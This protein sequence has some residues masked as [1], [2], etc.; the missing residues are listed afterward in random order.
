[1]VAPWMRRM[2]SAFRAATRMLARRFRALGTLLFSSASSSPDPH[3][4]KVEPTRFAQCISMATLPP[5]G[6]DTMIFTANKPTHTVRLP[7]QPLAVRNDCVCLETAPAHFDACACDIRTFSLA[8]AM[9]SEREDRRAGLSS[10]A[11]GGWLGLVS[12]DSAGAGG[13]L[14]S[15]TSCLEQAQSSGLLFFGA[16]LSFSA[17]DHIMIHAGA[18]F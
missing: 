17:G 13:G 12:H 2:G 18:A 1:M 10:I 14:G 4:S 5:T 6:S 11:S 15:T 9:A 3:P 8:T 7:H 16:S